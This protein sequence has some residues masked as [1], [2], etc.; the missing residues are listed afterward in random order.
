MDSNSTYMS[1]TLAVGS[2][3]PVKYQAAVDGCRKAFHGKKSEIV[4]AESYDVPSSVSE[5]PMTDTETK[6]GAT[7]RAVNAYREYTAAHGIPPTFSIGLEGGCML[8]DQSLQCFAWIAV[9][10]GIQVGFSRTASFILPN[11][12]RDLVV[13]DGLELGD[14]DYKVFGS[15]N[16]KQAGGTVGHLTNGVIDRTLYYEHAVILAFIPFQ[17]PSLYV[18]VN[19]ESVR[20]GLD[21]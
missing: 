18:A 4:V 1:I 19:G 6:T 2:K 9:Y 12:I 13:N 20:T 3:N 10:D 8:S 11:C 16:S 21:T 5:Q 17:W 15:T 7:N 14:A